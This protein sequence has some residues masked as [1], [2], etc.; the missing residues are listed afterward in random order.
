M[1]NG[2]FQRMYALP[3][4]EYQHLKSLQQT[5]NPIEKKFLDLSN[6]YKQQDSIQDPTVRVQ[7]QGET[8]H[9]MMNI[10]D[11]LKDRLIASTPKLYRS[12]ASSLFQFI[13]NKIGVNDKGELM[14]NKGSIIAGSNIGDLIQHAVRDRRRNIIPHGWTDFVQVL[15]ENNV[16]RMI[17]NY[18]TLEEMKPSRSDVKSAP[19]IKPSKLPL[20]IIKQRPLVKKEI[21]SP[22]RSR[23]KKSSRKRQPPD[24][25]LSKTAGI[26]HAKYI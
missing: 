24:Y 10:K 1:N 19:V 20:P 18:D 7:R 4:D 5:G 9:A 6:E 3:E 23:Q 15:Q 25:F 13:G 12:R 2:R 11:D 16:P 17:L 14:N 22:S 8:L 21:L 26:K